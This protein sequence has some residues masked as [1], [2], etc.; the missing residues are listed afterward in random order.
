LYH[1]AGN[2]P[3]RYV[4]PDGRIS[5]YLNDSTGAGGFGHSA[6]FVELYDNGKTWS[7]L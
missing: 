1:Y 3:V 4:D 7:K 2:N 5:G 6:L